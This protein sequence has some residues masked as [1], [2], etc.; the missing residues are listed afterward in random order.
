MTSP[1]AIANKRSPR[2]EWFVVL[3]T[4]SLTV[5]ALVIGRNFLGGEKRLIAAP[6]SDATL[7]TWCEPALYGRDVGRA[8]K[9]RAPINELLS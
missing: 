6:H 5:L 7:S 9:L 2:S 8:M 1:S 3:V 4:V